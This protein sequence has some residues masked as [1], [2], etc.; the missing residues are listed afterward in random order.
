MSTTLLRLVL[1]LVTAMAAG[2][3]AAQCAP[4]ASPYTDPRIVQAVAG[5]PLVLRLHADACGIDLPPSATLEGNVLR[6]SHTVDFRLP[7]TTERDVDYSFPAP[8][9]G[10]YILS[11]EPEPSLS[12]TCYPFTRLPF[13]VAPAGTRSIPLIDPRGSLGLGA[14]VL[15]L[16]WRALLRSA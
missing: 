6:V 13:G 14:L 7:C 12:F 10:S 3:A 15:L 1:L 16:G 9:A 4:S 5:Q 2:D 8:P 11:Y